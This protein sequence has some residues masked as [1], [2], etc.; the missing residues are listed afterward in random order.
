MD[1]P[2]LSDD[3][4]VGDSH[5]KSLNMRKLESA[6]KDKRLSNPAAAKPS[7]ASSY[8]TTRYW[9]NAKYPESNLEERV[10]KLLSERKCTNL[11]VLTPSNNITN[12]KD[13]PE[14]QQNQM[15]VDTPLETL[16]VVEK[17]LKDNPTLKKVVIVELPPRAD[18]DRLAELTEFS[19]FVLKGAVKNSEYR[20]K[21]SIGSL[22]SMFNYSE[23]DIYGSPNYHKYDGIHMHGKLG[24]KVFTNSVL[25]ALESAGLTSTSLQP[26]PHL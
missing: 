23:R 18:C 7:E 2:S 26:H 12:I 14:E 11:I 20:N 5:I 19:N 25:S 1:L 22:D 9:P 3:L 21:I 4:V 10:P 15:A 8:T 6:L 17:A 16:G 24:R 13:L